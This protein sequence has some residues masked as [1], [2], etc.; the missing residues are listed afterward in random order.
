MSALAEAL[1]R[2]SVRS[3]LISLFAMAGMGCP[4]RDNVRHNAV[5]YN[6]AWSRFDLRHGTF[7][8]SA[9]TRGSQKLLEPHSASA[10][11]FASTASSAFAAGPLITLPSRAKREPWHGQ[12]L[13]PV[14]LGP[15]RLRDPGPV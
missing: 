6:K 7:R 12:S 8:S 1:T 11:A 10:G 13:F 3:R 14:L 4:S 15:L 5:H 2:S 9:G